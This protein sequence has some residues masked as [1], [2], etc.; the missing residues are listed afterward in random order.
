[1]RDIAVT[2]PAAVQPGDMHAVTSHCR[3]EILSFVEIGSTI[4]GMHP[5]TDWST[6]VEFGRFRILPRQREPL[7]DDRPVELGS[8]A[9]ELL[10]ALIEAS[11]DVVSK[12]ALIERAWSGRIIEV[13]NLQLQMS[14]LRRALGADRGLIR[15]VAGQGYQFTGEIRK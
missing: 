1:M 2:Q 8:R 3:Q 13:N 14:G 5:V 10:L 6:V 7:A 4:G 9:F 12:Q 11:G 15:I